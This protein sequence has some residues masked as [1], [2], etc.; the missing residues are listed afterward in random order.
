M[1]TL[2]SAMAVV[3]SEQVATEASQISTRQ[4]ESMDG[5]AQEEKSVTSTSARNAFSIPCTSRCRRMNKM[6]KLRKK[7]L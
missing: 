6:L 7:P 4:L 3:S 1:M 2:G 5:D